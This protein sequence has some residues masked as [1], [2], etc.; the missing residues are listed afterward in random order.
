I[1]RESSSSRGL[2]RVKRMGEID[3]KPFEDALGKADF[4]ALTLCSEW[5]DELRDSN[6]FPF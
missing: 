5:Q 2:I 1:L 3:S 6:W 4:K